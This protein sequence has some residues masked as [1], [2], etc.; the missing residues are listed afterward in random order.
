MSEILLT[1]L[2]H[3]AA[4]Y[5]GGALVAFGVGLG[6]DGI[7]TE[8]PWRSLAGSAINGL[9]AP[10]LLPVIVHA[11][12]SLYRQQ[13]AALPPFCERRPGAPYRCA[14]STID[15]TCVFCGEPRDVD[16]TAAKFAGPAPIRT[17]GPDGPRIVRHD[18]GF[19]E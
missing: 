3:F 1:V 7:V 19:H 17:K 13:R 16:P 6:I 15:D 12:W 10:F 4:L 18:N 11:A 5:L 14:Y 2:T 8:S 9:L